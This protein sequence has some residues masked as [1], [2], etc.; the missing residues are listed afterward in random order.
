MSTTHVAG[1]GLADAGRHH[2]HAADWDDD[3]GTDYHMAPSVAQVT[4]T[5]NRESLVDVGWLTT[6]LSGQYVPGVSADFLA[7]GTLGVPGHYVTNAAGDVLQ[8]PD[9][10]GDWVHANQ[11]GRLLGFNPTTLTMA[12]WAAFSVNANDETATGIGFSDAGGGLLT[13]TDAVAVI[14]SDGSNF[15]CRSS[16]DSDAGAAVDTDWHLFKI[17]FAIGTT[18]KI[19]WFIDGVSQ[20]TLD[21]R[22][23]VLPMNWGAG[24]GAGLNNRILIGPVHLS[25][26]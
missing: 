15:I 26:R 4:T 20:G 11:S 5:G 14:H 6:G 12:A 9:L 18:D 8:S 25:Y 16:A 3:Y 23:G 10:F 13:A 21:L 22:T 17:V 19:E 7:E 24:V 1:M 2:V